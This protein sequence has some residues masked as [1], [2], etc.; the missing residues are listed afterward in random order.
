[1]VLL[2]A[3]EPGLTYRVSCY[4]QVSKIMLYVDCHNIANLLQS[5]FIR[6]FIPVYT[7]NR[8]NWIIKPC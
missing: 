7:A 6:G 3:E 8:G 5:G 1:M 4:K 2:G